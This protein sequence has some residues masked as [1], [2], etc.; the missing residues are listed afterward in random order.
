[1]TEII[2]HGIHKRF[3]ALRL[4]D[5]LSFEIS[6]FSYVCLL[7]PSGCGKTTLMRMIAGLEPMDGG[8]LFFGGTP[9][10]D[11]P[12]HARDVGLAFQNY[13]LY[14][15]LTVR[16]NLAFPLRAPGRRRQHT[17][18]DV[19]V[20]VTEIARRLQ[21]DLLLDRAVN[22][23]S[24]GQQQ[25]VALGRALIRR[26]RVLLLDE[27]VTHL[28]ARLRHE[29]RAELK[30]LH[31]DMETTTIHVTHDQ[32]EALAIADMIILMRDGRIEQAGAP[33]ALYHDPDT[34]FVAGFLGDP[35]MS[36]V[37]ATLEGIGDRPM[38]RVGRS[39]FDLPPELSAAV[40]GAD[41]AELLLGLRPANVVLADPGETGAL[42]VI[43]DARERIGRE[44]QLSVRLGDDLI[45]WR[46]GHPGT[47]EIGETM[48]VRLGLQGARLF[49]RRSGRAL[50]PRGR[51]AEIAG[52]NP[53]NVS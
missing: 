9:V 19:D 31:R 39:V 49:D 30:L 37:S 41:A 53:D 4:F 12:A 5:G 34:A 21:I 26:P 1:M 42:A 48:Y 40:A 17:D 25:R 23:L 2:G 13:A 6:P 28:D 22:Q 46:G 38:L 14:P 7:G 8:S 35:P 47:P 45:S 33:L 18:R 32:Q 16:G 27:P 51:M 3:G 52:A 10:N 11:L 50:R 29:M 15:H 36:L 24:G 44:L 20:R 43:I